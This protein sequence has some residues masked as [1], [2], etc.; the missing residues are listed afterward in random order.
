MV[1]EK[2]KGPNGSFVQLAILYGI[3]ARRKDG[4][5]I[6]GTRVQTQ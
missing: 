6:L 3:R 4:L 1:I 2:A 5:R